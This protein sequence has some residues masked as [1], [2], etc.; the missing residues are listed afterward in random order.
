MVTR[1]C[2][3][4]RRQSSSRVR[5]SSSLAPVTGGAGVPASAPGAAAGWHDT[6]PARPGTA[7]RRHNPAAARQG[8]A[9]CPEIWGSRRRRD[10]ID[11]MLAAKPAVYGCSGIRSRSS[12][13]ACSADPAGIE[14]DGTLAQLPDDGQVMGDE[15]QRHAPFAH[16]RPQQVQDLCLDR[17]VERRRGLIRDEQ[18]GLAGERHRDHHPLAHAARQLVRVALGARDRVGQTD[19]RQQLVHPRRGGAAYMPLWKRNASATCS[20]GS[21]QRVEGGQ[22]VLEDHRHLLAPDAS[23]RRLRQAHELAAGR[24]MLPRTTL[25]RRGSRPMMA[26]LVTL[27]P[28]PDR[29]PGPRSRRHA[30]Q[31]PGR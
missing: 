10:A 1:C 7:P 9:A 8:L 2:R 31:G 24:R 4:H 6:H 17:D 16:Q 26:R 5:W 11:G 22:R 30:G 18:R 19:V 20:P 12:T 21:V 15:Q 25:E 29:R 13:R 3:R 27:L 23:V 28:D 14:H